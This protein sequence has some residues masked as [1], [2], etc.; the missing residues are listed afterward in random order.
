VNFTWKKWLTFFLLAALP[1]TSVWIMY[2]FSVPFLYAC[3]GSYTISIIMILLAWLLF[4]HPLLSWIEGSG[5]IAA[6]I[7]STGIIPWYKVTI[8]QSRM[9]IGIGKGIK[10]FFNR[11]LFE[12]LAISPKTLEA[13]EQTDSNGEEEIVFR[14]K[15]EDYPRAIF[16]TTPSKNILFFNGKSLRVVTKEWIASGEDK[17]LAD[18]MLY[19]LKESVD[20]LGE[21]MGPFAKYIVE[22]M[23]R[24]LG[25]FKMPSWWIIIIIVVLLAVGY[26]AF[27]YL[28]SMIGGAAGTVGELGGNRWFCG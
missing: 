17:L 14:L 7:N 19:D 4:R 10:S 20:T 26:F 22:I 3:I 15:K 23:A 13:T 2:F 18:H 12:P 1:V 24:A 28:Q 6:D 11:K 21:Q 25:G 27:P 5:L 16:G 9:T 8:A